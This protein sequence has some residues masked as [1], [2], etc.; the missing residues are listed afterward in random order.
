MFQR[1]YKHVDPIPPLGQSGFRIKDS[2]VLQLTLI[3]HRLAEALDNKGVIASCYFD[4]SK[5]FDR[6]SLLSK[7][8]L[9][10]RFSLT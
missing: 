4:L 6:A 7:G 5:A 10:L 1:A 2:T 8:A 9:T 3:V